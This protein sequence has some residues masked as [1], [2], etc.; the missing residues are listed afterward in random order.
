MLKKILV[1]KERME[2]TMKRKM[3]ILLAMILVLGLT[4]CD[5]AEQPVEV[6]VG[7]TETVPDEFPADSPSDSSGITY[8]GEWKEYKKLEEAEV[9]EIVLFG[10]NEL[11]WWVVEKGEDYAYLLCAYIIDHS[12][13]VEEI[14]S[15]NFVISY[16]YEMFNDFNSK[17]YRGQFFSSGDMEKML[18]TG[19]RFDGEELYMTLPDVEE[20]VRWF[21]DLIESYKYETTYVS[22]NGA[23][24]LSVDWLRVKA[25][26]DVSDIRLNPPVASFVQVSLSKDDEYAKNNWWLAES[27]LRD[28]EKLYIPYWDSDENPKRSRF[29]MYN[30]LVESY[31]DGP[32]AGVRPVI[33]VKVD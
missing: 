24:P 11:A 22:S 3:L 23:K 21:P 29:E 28:N 31:C 19:D 20:M 10:K 14:L 33:K 15:P 1:K 16:R 2:V 9:G 32:Y 26:A 25:G 6:Y 7:T 27:L 5:N 17:E 8:G 4:A 18:P 30:W 12:S 13:Y